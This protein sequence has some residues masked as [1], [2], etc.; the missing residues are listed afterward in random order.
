MVTRTVH[1]FVVG[2]SGLILAVAC[3]TA[4]SAAVDVNQPATGAA[5]EAPPAVVGEDAKPEDLEPAE[6]AS[7]LRARGEAPAARSI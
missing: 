7:G 3:G 2:L 6:G 5:L 1:G 4:R